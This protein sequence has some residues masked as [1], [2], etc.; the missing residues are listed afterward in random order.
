M[1]ALLVIGALLIAI[2]VIGLVE[3][4]VTYVKNKDNLDLGPVDISVTEKE[5][6]P[7]RPAISV[8]ALVGGLLLIGVG[9]RQRA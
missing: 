5:R 3:G 2:G 9:A 7:L 6:I 4:G 8:V 1:K